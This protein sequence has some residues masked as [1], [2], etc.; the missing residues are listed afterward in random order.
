[1]LKGAKALPTSPALPY[2]NVF[3]DVL[4]GTNNALG[5]PASGSGGNVLI[6][7]YGAGPGYDLV[8]GVGAPFGGHLIQA[9]TGQAVP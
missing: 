5:P 3:Y 8:T 9:I 1:M 6:A 4:Y 2:A 7:G